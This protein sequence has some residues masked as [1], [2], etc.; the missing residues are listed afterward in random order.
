MKIVCVGRNYAEHARELGNPLPAEPVIFLKPETALLPPGEPFSLPS[1]SSDVHYELEVVLRLSARARR[2]S[3][4]A[5]S[6]LFE[7][8][9]LGIDFTA[10]DVQR[11]CREKGLP[12]ERAKAFDGAAPIGRFL[13]KQSLGDLSRLEFCLLRNGQRV[14]VGNTRDLVFGF[15]HLISFVSGFITLE[16]GDLLFSGTPAGVGAVATGDLLE[17]FMGD[18]KLLEVRVV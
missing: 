7:E 15:D 1:H 18:E 5:A 12:W 2:V 14:Q 3:P 11:M 6:R 9:G 10:R 8:I 4:T 13:P 16:P 17:G